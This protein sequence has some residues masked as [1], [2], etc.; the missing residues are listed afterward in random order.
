MF[1]NYVK[2]AFKVLLRRKFFTF[3]SL[4]AISF[5]L[6][7]LMVAAALLDHIFATIPPETH[8]DR[9]I[10]IPYV[11]ASGEHFESTGNPG[12]GLLDLYCRN[13][14][15]AEKFSIFCS[16]TP[17]TSYL[18]G[19]KMVSYLKRTDGVFWEILDF[20]FLEGAPYTNEN[21]KNADFVAVINQATRQKFFGSG[22]ALG[23]NI[24]LA[25]ER[26]RVVGVVK[27]VPDYRQIPFADVWVPISASKSKSY[28]TALRGGFVG[29]VLAHSPADFPAIKAELTSRMKQVQVNE[30]GFNK[31]EAMAETVLET[32]AREMSPRRRDGST[33]ELLAAGL[34]MALLFMLLPTINLININV[35][36]IL[37]RSSEIGV[38]KAFG[39]SSWSLVGQFVI[40]NIILTLVGGT[41]AVA[42]TYPVLAVIGQSRLFLYADLHLNWRIFAYGFCL[43]LFFGLLSGVYPAWKMSRLHP[44]QAL[45]GGV[46]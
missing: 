6:V 41:L 18:N 4:F 35:S 43:A 28:R 5:T 7:V 14:P 2:I 8:N 25:G 22:E 45:K 24:E 33:F 44:V 15:G 3:I 13:L 29:L 27:N 16:Q 26:F 10:T 20:Q 17:V 21:E 34:V 46:R 23:K 36:R 32:T 31:V 9:T 1:K 11:R 37:E 38:R 12:Y 19:Q 39:A 30:S 40:E 42:L